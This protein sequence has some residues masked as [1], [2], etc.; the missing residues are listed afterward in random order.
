MKVTY[1]VVACGI[2]ASLLLA[3]CE[4]GTLTLSVT[5]AP[6]DKATQVRVQFTEVELIKADGST[7]SF[8]LSPVKNVDLLN[9][10]GGLST[11]LLDQVR[12]PDGEYQGLRLKVNAGND[13]DDS[14]L[15]L[16]TGAQEALLL[17]SANESLLTINQSF[18]VERRE[19]L[20]LT[21]DFDL[22]KSVLEPSSD[23]EPYEL[24]PALRLVKDDDAGTIFGTVPTDVASAAGCSPVVYVYSG[25]DVTVNDV[26]S[27]IPPL[28]SALVKFNSVSDDFEYRVAFLNAGDYTA[29]FTCDARDDDPETDDDTDLVGA[30]N[31]AVTAK[32]TTQANF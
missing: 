21:V 31:V 14:F 4:D 16:D 2:A 20:A 5:D 28:A 19:E 13:A 24:R 12:V 11:P 18:T 3:G 6:V 27:A 1:T 22:R 32:Q 17:P 15:I 10:S 29:A 25:K 23:G 30:R 26:G 9:F 7:E 8:E